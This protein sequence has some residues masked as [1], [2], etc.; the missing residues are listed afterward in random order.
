VSSAVHDG[1][2][3]RVQDTCGGCVFLPRRG[4]RD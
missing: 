1:C 4:G 3:V 2:C